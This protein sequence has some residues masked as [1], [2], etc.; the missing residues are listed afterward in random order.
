MTV[1]AEINGETIT[2]KD[3]EHTLGTKLAQ[4]EEQIHALKRDKLNSL[5]VG[6]C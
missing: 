5:I 6:D 2:T 3:L 1:L 4:Y